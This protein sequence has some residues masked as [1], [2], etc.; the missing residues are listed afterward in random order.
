MSLGGIATSERCPLAAPPPSRIPAAQNVALGRP[1]AQSSVL[2][3]GS[4]A[5]KAVDGNRD[6]DWEHGSCAH[7]AEEPEPWWHVDLGRRHSVYAVLVQNRRD[8]C[9][10]RL[11]GAQVHV[12]DSLVDH[13]RRN[14]M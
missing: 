10:Q 7:T 1:A 11:R 9:W 5:G 13:G 14:P 8:C 6:S 4:D 3:P 12:G 2:E